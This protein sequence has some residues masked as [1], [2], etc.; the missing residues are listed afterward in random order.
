M[1][2]RLVFLTLSLSCSSGAW[3]AGE[4]LLMPGKVIS[5]HA[6]LEAK[7]EECHVK[8]DKDA[9]N[10]LCKDCHKEVKADVLN[11][12]GFH[13]RLDSEKDCKE[14]HTDHKGR[15]AKIVLLDI[16]KFDHDKTDYPL[17]GAHQNKD[18]VKCKDCHKPEKKYREAPSACNDCHLKDDKHKGSLGKECENCHKETNWKEAKFDHS[19]T[20]FALAG[21]HV[22]V[23]CKKC[24][25]SHPAS[26]KGASMECV[27]CHRKDD[28][29]KG[30]YGKKCENCHV[31]R[32]WKTIDFD[33]DRET[34]YKL[35]GKHKSV[36]CMSCHTEP[37]YRKESK[38]PSNCNACHR[39]D[40]V[41]KGGLGVKCETCHSEINWKTAKFD[42]DKDTKF[43]LLGKHITTKCD[44]CHKPNLTKEKLATTCI[45]CHKSDDKH[46]G[47]FGAK[48]DSCHKEKDWKTISFDHQKDTKYPLKGKHEQVK[49][50]TCHTG[51]LYDQKLAMDCF[52]C[53]KKDDD[54]V[55]KLKLGKKCES[56]HNEKDWKEDNFDHA[57]SRFPLLGLHQKVE[58]KKCHK[59]QLYLDSPS[60]CFSCHQKDD[61]HKL[62]LGKKCESCHNTRS[63]KAWDFDHDKRT[64]FKLDGG[65]KTTDCYACH[66][67]EM[68]DKVIVARTCIGCHYDDDVHRGEFGQQCERCHVAKDWKTVLVGSGRDRR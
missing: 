6:K 63:W 30:N 20:K 66:K 49:C 60:D 27:S 12:K 65:H 67:K 19:K 7:C 9:Q 64:K 17:R 25:A 47:N 8:F 61:V 31:D 57:L 51:K 4:S 5:G 36:K 24:H 26:Y 22:D 28:K 53:H 44:A 32:D 16:N 46:K 62:R 56:C 45:G 41:H 39:K 1:L 42:H 55:H 11:K 14:C 21:K 50:V 40:D 33:H 34:K 58:C 13:G 68:D 52:A 59:T 38:T 35:L 48:C 37:L 3:A 23:T 10:R 18:K 43:P 15:D 54:K 2:I 29:H